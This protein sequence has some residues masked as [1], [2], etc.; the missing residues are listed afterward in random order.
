M[1]FELLVC[2]QFCGG[3]RNGCAILE[4]LMALWFAQSLQRM[5]LNGWLDH[6]STFIFASYKASLEIQWLPWLVILHLFETMSGWSGISVVFLM[7]FS[8]SGIRCRADFPKP[9]SYKFLWALI[10][11]HSCLS[12]TWYRDQVHK[13]ESWFCRI[14]L[15]LHETRSEPDKYRIKL[16]YN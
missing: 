9:V 12:T 5:S 8:V 10:C 16:C 1:K 6:S 2:R 4:Y 15:V 3:D 13:E 7:S 11:C 14:F